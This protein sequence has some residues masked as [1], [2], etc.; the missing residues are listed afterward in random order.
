MDLLNSMITIEMDIEQER[1][2]RD[3]VRVTSVTVKRSDIQKVVRLLGSP[4]QT[5][6][7]GYIHMEIEAPRPWLAVGR[8][9]PD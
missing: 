7:A 3:I 5:Y 8:N 1:K 6:N 2:L 4:W 9:D